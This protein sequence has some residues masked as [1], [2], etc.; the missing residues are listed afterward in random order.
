MAMAKKG[1]SIMLD[2][3]EIAAFAFDPH[4]SASGK[5]VVVGTSHGNVATIGQHD[6]KPIVVGFNA[7]VRA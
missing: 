7:Y 4:G 6:G 2:G 3:V 5:T 1:F